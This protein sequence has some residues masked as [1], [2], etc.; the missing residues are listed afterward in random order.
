METTCNCNL[1]CNQELQ[2]VYKGS[3]PTFNFNVCLATDEVDVTNTH[4]IFTSGPAIVD[5]TNQDIEVKEGMLSCSLTQEETMSF[6]GTQVNIQI[7]A[8]MINGQ[9]LAS[10]IITVPVSSTLLGGDAW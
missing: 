6:K 8:T 2:M 1:D 10:V 7:L 3:T 9:K 4:I 5:K